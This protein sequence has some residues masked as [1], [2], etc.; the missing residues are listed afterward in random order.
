MGFV[1]SLQVPRRRR[2]GNLPNFGDCFVAMLLAMT[3]LCM[4]CIPHADAYTGRKAILYARAQVML[5][6][7]AP[8]VL[9][10][11]D[12]SE[13]MWRLLE[14]LWPELK[15]VRWFRRTSAT[16]MAEWPW[17]PLMRLADGTF[18]DLLF[19][20][21]EEYPKSTGMEAGRYR[22]PAKADFN[23][24]HVMMHW[25]NPGSAIHSGKTKGFSETKLR[26]DW[27]PRITLAIRPPY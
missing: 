20:N 3:I 15:L 11:T 16:A 9:G 23:I 2:D 26:P 10:K 17:A 18:G 12:C 8:W 1:P 21:S 25:T 6:E 5:V 14:D 4:A 24:N 7:N 22:R 19:A 27:L 13:R